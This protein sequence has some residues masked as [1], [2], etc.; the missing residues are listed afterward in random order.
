MKAK[1]MLKYRGLWLGCAMLWIVWYHL[2]GNLPPYPLSSIASIGYGGVDICLFASGIGC[3][4]SL[5]RTDELL[6]F[7]KRRFVRIMPTY[8]CFVLFWIIFRM[9]TIPLAKVDIWGNILGIQALTTRGEYFNWYISLIILLYVMAPFFFA[10]AKGIDGTARQ[11][12]VTL[13]FVV[14]SVAFWKTTVPVIVLTRFPIFYMGMLFG[15]FS[16]KGGEIG[17]KTGIIMGLALIAGAL[18]LKLFFSRYM[19]HLWS[20][21]LFWYPFILITPGLCAL[22]SLVGRFLE[23][24]ALGRFIIKCVEKVGDYSFELYLIHLF[25]FDVVIY[26]INYAGLLPASII[27]WVIALVAVALGTVALRYITKLVLWC[28]GGLTALARKKAKV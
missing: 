15:K 21:G 8:F 14:L 5:S 26:M 18:L 7:Y 6:D 22:I 27:S 12:A 23:K 16:M 2:D 13:F 1:D 25:F 20:R 4:Y 28:L 11:T 9:H 24:Y 17:K 3:W 10:L 19:G